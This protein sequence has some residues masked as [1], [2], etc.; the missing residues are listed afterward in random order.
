MKESLMRLG[1]AGSFDADSSSSSSFMARLVGFLTFQSSGNASRGSFHGSDAGVGLGLG[2][3]P[4]SSMKGYQYGGGLGE[5]SSL[6]PFE[7]GAREF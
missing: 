7:E 2:G 4:R 3:S 5:G 6:L 1:S